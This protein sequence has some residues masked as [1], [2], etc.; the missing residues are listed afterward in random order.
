MESLS[1]R[2]KKFISIGSDYGYGYGYGS[3]CGSGNIYGYGYGK[4]PVYGHSPDGF[5]YNG[6]GTG[7][8]CGSIDGSGDGSGDSA[9]IK[10][11]NGHNVYTID[12]TQTIIYSIFGNCAYGAILNCDLTTTPCYIA[13]V[14]VFF[15]HGKTLK[16]AYR[17]AKNKWWRNRPIEDRI[18]EFVKI[19]PEVDTP[20]NDLFTWHNTLTGSCEMGRKQWCKT[21]GYKPDDSITIREFIEET[22]ND[23]GGD[24]IIQLAKAYNQ[25]PHLK[26]GDFLPKN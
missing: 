26:E 16:E 8:G 25:L 11:Y 12:D 20:Y 3:D 14:N 17:D 13:K 18:N 15:A 21:H 24:I 7:N 6:Y 4:G 22:K 19:H 10:S 23:Y 9:G 5:Y 1:E 2:V